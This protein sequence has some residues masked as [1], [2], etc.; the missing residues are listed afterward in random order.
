MSD[1]IMYR[2]IFLINWRAFYSWTLQ[3]AMHAPKP[4]QV[5][6]AFISELDEVRPAFDALVIEKDQLEVLGKAIFLY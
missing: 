5:W 6:F 1:M 2:R 3:A 4:S